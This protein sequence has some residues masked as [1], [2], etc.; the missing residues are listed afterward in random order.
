MPRYYNYCVYTPLVGPPGLQWQENA[1]TM[2]TCPECGQ[3]FDLIEPVEGQRILC[4]RCKTSLEVVN[5]EPLEL[6]WV[7]HQPVVLLEEIESWSGQLSLF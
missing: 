3:V 4:L 5:L 2:A 7:Y 1:M 6:D